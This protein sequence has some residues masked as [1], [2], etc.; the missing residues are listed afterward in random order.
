MDEVSEQNLQQGT[1]LIWVFSAQGF[2]GILLRLTAN[3]L[4]MDAVSEQT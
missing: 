1:V 3:V 4:S 2:A